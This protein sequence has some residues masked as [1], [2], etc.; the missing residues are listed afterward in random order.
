MSEPELSPAVVVGAGLIGASIGRALT[1]AGVEVHL[2]D[3]VP[4]HAV[5]AAT[6]GAGT[7]D[8]VD[9][10]DVRLVVVAVPPAALVRVVAKT[11]RTYPNATVTD[12]GSVKSKVLDELWEIDGL[13]LGRYVGS[14]PMAGTQHT[15][16]LTASPTLFTDRTWVIAPHR[17]SSPDATADVRR[18]AEVCG[19]TIVTFDVAD[20][21]RAV[22]TVSHVP[23]IMSVLTAGQLLDHTAEDLRLAGPGVRD[24]TRVAA[25]DPGLWRQIIAANAGAVRVELEQISARLGELL[26]DL[27]DEEA[28]ERILAEGR[29]GTRVLPGKHGL[30]PADFGQVVVELPDTP[31]SLSRLFRDVDALGVN[32]E[33]LDIDHDPVRQVGYLAISVVWDQVEE[34]TRRIREAGWTVRGG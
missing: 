13:D 26:A 24:V 2:T 25:S 11:L 10:A 33:D 32:V 19:A 30:A 1:V 34:L 7:T 5:V 28:V 16:P 9:P 20:H 22:A 15:G 12:V 4:S 17:A 14:H 6:I 27:D 21:D 3:R 23:Y 8:P 31:G 29:D 18:L